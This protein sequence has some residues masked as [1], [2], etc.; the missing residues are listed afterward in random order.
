MYD[1][2]SRGKYI[3]KKSFPLF[4][5]VHFEILACI[6]LFVFFLAEQGKI[7]FLGGGGLRV[8][9]SGEFVSCQPWQS[10]KLKEWKENTS[11]KVRFNIFI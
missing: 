4:F 3:L 7:P 5:E 11:H 8:S 2:V 10:M 1:Q 6:F 9:N